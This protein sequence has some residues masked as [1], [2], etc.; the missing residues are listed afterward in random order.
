MDYTPSFTGSELVPESP[1]E[2]EP[3]VAEA[4]DLALDA[5]SRAVMGVVERIGP[6]V[7]GVATWG[8]DGRALGSGSGFVLTPDGYVLTNDHVIRADSKVVVA[9]ADGREIAAQVVGADPATDLAL[10]RAEADGLAYAELAQRGRPKAGQLVVAIGNPLGYQSTVS[11][12]VVSAIDRALRSRTGRLI[13][14]VIQ[15]TAALNPGNSGGPLLNSAGRVIGIN[16]AIIGGAQALGFAVGAGTATWVVPKL[17]Q[18]GRVRRATLGLAAR[19]RVL[20]RRLARHTAVETATVVEA[21]RAEPGG[22]ADRAGLRSGDLLLALDERA[23]ANVDDLHRLLA[24]WTEGQRV[25]VA[26]LRG[27]KRLSFAVTPDT[28]S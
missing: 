16:T 15:H 26:V 22:P 10:L 6:A 28:L 17:L 14:G 25:T 11:A 3:G 21:V 7:V 13:E 2:A 19:V 23:I 8:R 27:T 4:D 12:G 20:D 1:P 5:Y 18:H 24:D 9:L